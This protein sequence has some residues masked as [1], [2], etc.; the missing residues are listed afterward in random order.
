MEAE[1]KQEFMK[2]AS[3][4]YNAGNYEAALET[5]KKALTIDPSN[6]RARHGLARSLASLHQCREA[7]EEFNRV[8]R[9]DGLSNGW[10]SE[11]YKQRGDVYFELQIS[12][13]LRGTFW[14]YDQ[15]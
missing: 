5:Y 4:H 14:F 10:Y 8:L 11:L 7:L 1:S 12:G 6:L 13:S 15:V 3:L 2:L 9:Y